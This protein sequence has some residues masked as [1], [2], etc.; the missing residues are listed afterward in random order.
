MTESRQH[1]FSL[2]EMVVVVAVLSIV[3]VT[4][5][6][7]VVFVAQWYDQTLRQNRVDEQ[8]L[9][10]VTRIEREVRNLAGFVSTNVSQLSLVARDGQTNTI[11]WISGELR[12][13]SFVLADG[14]T[15][16]AMTYY[17]ATNGAAATTNNIQRINLDLLIVDGNARA[18]TDVNFFCPESGTMK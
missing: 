16:C 6:R 5:F 14:V 9:A 1:G 2:L 17:D 3:A 11:E 10:A 12:L 7:F 8:T 4:S 13:N 15:R 18:D